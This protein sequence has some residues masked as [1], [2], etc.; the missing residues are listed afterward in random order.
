MG[1][2]AKPDPGEE[3]VIQFPYARYPKNLKNLEK[4]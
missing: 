1:R 4:E 2:L 3:Q